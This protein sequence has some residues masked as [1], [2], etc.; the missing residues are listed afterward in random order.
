MVVLKNGMWIIGEIKKLDRGKLEYST[1]DIGRIRIVA[2]IYLTPPPY[3][4]ILSS[5]RKGIMTTQCPKCEAEN[6][7]TQSF[8]DDCGTQLGP[9]SVTK[10]LKVPPI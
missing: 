8:C 6:P 2:E 3:I 5:F 9:L 10:T 7:D 4:Y 1:D